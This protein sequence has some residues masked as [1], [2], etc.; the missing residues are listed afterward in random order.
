MTLEQLRIFTMVAELLSMTRAAERLHLTQPAV[1]ASVA[2]LEERYATKLFDRVGRRLELTEAGRLFLPQARAVLV[3][4]DNARQVLENLAGL[5]R[6][7]VRIAAS[8]TVATYWLP[9][10]MAAF[11]EAYPKIHLRLHV[12]NTAQT[13]AH[14]LHGT[15][16]FGVVE[17]DVS[18][19]MLETRIVG[20]DHIGIYAAPDHPLARG[21]PTREDLAGAVWVMREPGSGTRDHLNAGLAQ[22]GIAVEHLRTLLELPSNGAVLEAIEGGGLVAGVSEL[23]AVSRVKAGLVRRLDWSLPSRDF[24]LLTHRERYP[25]RAVRAFVDTL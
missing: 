19:A 25:G 4:G 12:G 17:G 16:D 1:S 6:G 10:R 7:E 24:L 3:Q 23:A 20:S 11:A 2:A 5:L 22:S 15:A 14:V 8:Q 9:R 18:E 21:T 13:A